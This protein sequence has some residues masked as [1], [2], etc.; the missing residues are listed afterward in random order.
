[1]KIKSYTQFIF[2]ASGTELVGPIGPGYGDTSL[3]NKTISSSDTSV[4]YSDIDGHIYTM[5]EYN[6]IYN[7]YL[8]K[9]GNP[10]QGFTLDNIN[11][12]LSFKSSNENNKPEG[13]MD[14]RSYILNLENVNEEDISD[15]LSGI[16]DDNPE[17]ITRIISKLGPSDPGDTKAGWLIAI[18]AD[19]KWD[20]EERTFSLS[21]DMKRSLEHLVLF[22]KEKGLTSSKIL[23][24][25]LKQKNKWLGLS[26]K[27]EEELDSYESIQ[28]IPNNLNILRISMNFDYTF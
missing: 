1:M 13:K 26:K 15:I 21:K 6:Q 16:S 3:P 20:R 2:E 27:M 28:S 4:I 22:M 24:S 7:D 5:D 23:I 8:K 25:S 17:I 18:N 9:G 14:K 12:I 19:D 11:T 10:L